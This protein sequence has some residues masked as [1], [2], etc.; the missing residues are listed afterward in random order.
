MKKGVITLVL[1][2]LWAIGAMP[3]E[4]TYSAIIKDRQEQVVE[5]ATVMLLDSDS[6]VLTVGARML[7]GL[8]RSGLREQG[9]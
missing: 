3:Q 7:R 1:C 6:L 5:F 8:F 4:V 2:M 9:S